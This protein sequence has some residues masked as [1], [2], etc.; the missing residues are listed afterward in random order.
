MGSMTVG[1]DIVQTLVR[2]GVTHAFGVPGE[3]FLGVLDAMGES[4]SI[5]VISTRH[6]GG[7]AFMAEAYAKLTSTPS[8]CMGTRMV[9]AANLA[10]GLHT[11]QQDSSPVIALVGQ[12]HSSRRHRESFQEAEIA[13]VFR[14][15]V[16]WTAEPADPAAARRVTA[17]ACR[18][19]QTGRP[20]AVVISLTEDLLDQEAAVG[21][22]FDLEPA[23]DPAPSGAA[24][25]KV[26][27]ALRSAARPVLLLG[28]DVIRSEAG[29]VLREVA[30]R[31]G[32]PVIAAW[33][34]PDV[35]D[36]TDDHYLGHAGYGAPASVF[37]VLGGADVILA[38]GT[39]LDEVTTREYAIPSPTTQLFQVTLDPSTSAEATVISAGAREF[40]EALLRPFIGEPL[41]D[42][43]RR[44]REAEIS[45]RR[46]I[47][48]S[49]ATPT[50][51]ETPSEFIDQRTVVAILQ[52][53]SLPDTILT[54]DA[55]NFSG[56]AARYFRWRS[57]RTFLGPTS[58][59][60]G[61]A[62]PA[63]IAA[64]AARPDS[65]VIA[66]AGD[67]GFMMTGAELETA[68]RENLP[69]V[70]LVHDNRSFGTIAMHQRRRTTGIGV[71][72]ELG[73]IDFAGFARSLGAVGVTVSSNADIRSVL[74]QALASDRP[75]VVHLRTDPEQHAVS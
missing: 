39:R 72:T 36:N 48:L 9:G 17:R 2:A 44:H 5:R 50:A 54:T 23:Y 59:A 49:E 74:R 73:P 13:D 6:E 60:M 25:T 69:I 21:G 11:A 45:V 41:D 56:W 32:L 19:A 33:R 26:S 24:V 28:E 30:H 75:Y 52:D 64:K 70:V 61:Y 15:I 20:G 68:V 40:G 62:V 53:L 57:P 12:V 34:R 8:V 66:L 67:G 27:R 10:I 63:A 47:W 46:A 31:A 51:D 3:S 14:P 4:P 71:G 42:A 35:F 58:G 7:A 55:G 65:A 29:D 22:G 37:D 16:K 18:V 38:V 43:T 1:A